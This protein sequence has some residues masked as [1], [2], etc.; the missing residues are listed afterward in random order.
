M[1]LSTLMEWDDIKAYLTT[2]ERIMVVHGIDRSRWAYKL[3]PELTGKAQLAYVAMDTTASG[4]YEELKLQSSG[5]TILTKKR[6]AN[7]S[8]LQVE[9]TGRHTVNW[10]CGL[11]TWWINGHVSVH[12]C[13]T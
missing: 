9:R 13:R 8:E 10:L 4:D 6:I 3:A 12:L 11:Q 2:F 5:G 7:V 1:K